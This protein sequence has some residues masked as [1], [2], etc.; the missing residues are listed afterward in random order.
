MIRENGIFKCL[1]SDETFHVEIIK[2]AQ[3]IMRFVLDL[4]EISKEDIDLIWLNSM[5]KQEAD[6]LRIFE[7]IADCVPESAL[8]LFY[9]LI[10]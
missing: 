4:E 9:Q 6:R 10:K 2:R 5:A 8:P 1:L 7:S 3:P